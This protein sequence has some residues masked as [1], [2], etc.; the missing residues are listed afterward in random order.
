MKALVI[1]CLLIVAAGAA[2]FY[3]YQSFSPCDWMHQDLVEQTGLPELVIEA[4]IKA[5]F[6][7]DGITDPAPHECLVEWWEVRLNGLPEEN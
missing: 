4:R 3:R 6:L 2:T 7:L 1:V 5:V